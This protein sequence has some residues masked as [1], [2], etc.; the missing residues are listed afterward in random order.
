MDDYTRHKA[1]TEAL[2]KNI[3]R[4]SSKIQFSDNRAVLDSDSYWNSEGSTS[5]EWGKGKG[6][7]GSGEGEKEEGAQERG[8]LMV[9]ARHARLGPCL[10]AR[11]PLPSARQTTPRFILILFACCSV[12]THRERSWAYPLLPLPTVPKFPFRMQTAGGRSGRRGMKYE[13]EILMGVKQKSLPC[14]G[15]VEDKGGV[16]GAGSKT[17]NSWLSPKFRSFEYGDFDTVLTASLVINFNDAKYFCSPEVLPFASPCQV[18]LSPPQTPSPSTEIRTSPSWR[19]PSSVLALQSRHSSP[20][21]SYPY[22]PYIAQPCQPHCHWFWCLILPSFF[23]AFFR[24]LNSNNM[25]LSYRWTKGLPWIKVAY[26]ERYLNAPRYLN[27]G[28]IGFSELLIPSQ[29]WLGF[30]R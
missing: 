28:L 17:L 2:I 27:S 6:Y 10:A 19:P 7:K 24:L 21:S 26:D 11:G 13:R 1:L 30:L 23:S 18:R 15:T 20:T 8:L 5:E 29:N 12:C 25:I 22:D 16:V 4:T 3:W 14:R 9:R